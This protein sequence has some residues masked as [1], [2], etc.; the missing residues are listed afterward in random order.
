MKKLLTFL[1][2]LL[3]IATL[4]LSAFAASEE[5]YIY[6]FDNITVIFEENDIF[7]AATREAVA[8]KLAHGDN[9]VATYGLWCT[10][11]VHDY[12]Q[13]SVTTITQCVDPT[14][15]RCLQEFFIVKVCTDCEDTIVERTGLSY[16]S[17]CP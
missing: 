11:F 17:C 13:S 8:H 5:T 6:E 2:T 14:P 16:I 12:E 15:P 7:D 9:G 4:S 3:L 1:L 10:L